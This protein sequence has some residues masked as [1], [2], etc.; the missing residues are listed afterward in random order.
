MKERKPQTIEELLEAAEVYREARFDVKPPKS[1]LGQ[2]IRTFKSERDKYGPGSPSGAKEDS[3]EAKNARPQKVEGRAELRECFICRKKGHI[4][5]D[6]RNKTPKVGALHEVPFQGG[7]EME[8]EG[9]QPRDGQVGSGKLT[10]SGMRNAEAAAELPVRK[11]AIGDRE[12]DVLRDTGCSTAVVRTSFV[13]DREYTGERR[14]CVLIDGTMREFE[15]AKLA[16][17]TPFLTGQLEALVMQN[18]LCD[19]I[20]G[21]VPGASCLLYTSDA[22]DES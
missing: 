18:P 4:A 22:A 9:S 2:Q 8:A 10:L 3:P 13:T 21:N 11:G 7:T 16:V 1:G 17:S 14:K 6:C 12:V 15:T 19:L 20:I 5:R